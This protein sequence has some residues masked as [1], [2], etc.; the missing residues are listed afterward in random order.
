MGAIKTAASVLDPYRACVA[1][2]NAAVSRGADVYE[3]SE[4]LRIRARSRSVE[5]TTAAERFLPN[6]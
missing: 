1:M 6:R 4:V 2:L 5:V 3:R